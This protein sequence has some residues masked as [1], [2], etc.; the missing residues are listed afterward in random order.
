MF[1]CLIISHSNDSKSSKQ[2]HLFQKKK[3]KQASTL[4][5]NNVE[6]EQKTYESSYFP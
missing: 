5:V 6:H 3:K 1:M 4:Q 2:A